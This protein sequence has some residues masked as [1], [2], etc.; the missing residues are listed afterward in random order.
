M[1]KLKTEEFIQRS[2]DIHGDKYGYDK[3]VYINS[4][5]KVK[6]WCNT[7]KKYF[8]QNPKHHM[9]GRGC[10]Y[11]GNIIISNK[12][13][14]TLEYFIIDSINVHGDMYGY[15]RTI[16]INSNTKIEIYCKKCKNYFWQLPLNHLRGARCR[17]CADKKE[18]IRKTLT[19]KEFKEKSTVVH[20][21]NRYHYDKV[22]YDG[23]KTKVKIWCNTCKKYFWQTPSMHLQGQG[24]PKCRESKGE[25]EISK[26]LD[27]YKIEYISQKWFT[28][29]RNIHPLP[30]D[31]YISKYNICI[32]YQGEQHYKTVQGIGNKKFTLEESKQNFKKQQKHD[33]IKREYCKNN[34]ITLIEI[35]YWDFKNIES[36]IVNIIN[37]Y[38]LKG[39]C[40]NVK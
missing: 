8:W 21:V 25:K 39:V 12:H 33:N 23:S 37:I 10:K 14:K 40:L 28:D 31:F 9:Y 24:C 20:G 11:C 13:R 6:I 7:C 18:C 15:D 3:S 1:R 5:T 22:I 19:V 2:I 34:N 27:K 16:Y 26:Y 4:R 38:K 29:C 30:F 17:K 36:I 32:E 35:P